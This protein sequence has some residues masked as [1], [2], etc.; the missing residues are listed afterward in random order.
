MC[1]NCLS[2]TGFCHINYSEKGSCTC[3]RHEKLFKL[4]LTVVI[5]LAVNVALGGLGL[6]CGVV[7]VGKVFGRHG[8]HV[9]PVAPAL[10]F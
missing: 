8:F 2:N 4:N 1:I 9:G 5:I 3:T 6:V 7:L 10:A